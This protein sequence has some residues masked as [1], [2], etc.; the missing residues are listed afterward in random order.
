MST[1]TAPAA[2]VKRAPEEI[3][4]EV[5]L[6]HSVRVFRPTTARF[7]PRSIELPDD[8][9]NP[10]ADELRSAV[11]GMTAA[12]QR[13]HDAPMM[14]KKMRDAENARKMS[15]FKRVLIR[16]LL[17]DRVM[18]QGVFEPASTV[19]MVRRFVVASLRDARNVKFYLFVTPPKQKLTEMDKTLWSLGLVPA[20][21]I[22]M[23]I[24][25][26]EEMSSAQLLKDWLLDSMED[27]PESKGVDR[28][29][30]TSNT[31]SEKDKKETVKKDTVSQ[32]TKT[33]KI[34]KWFK[35]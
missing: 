30:G 34:P 7:D 9:F 20:A 2:P 11:A 14:T 13:L 35:K 18:L 31:P 28:G 27:A 25:S 12:S 29:V 17:P 10:T 5:L 8:F 4:R 32:K 15:R 3:A 16:I 22:H 19:N 23:G 6:K 26:G 33:K 24:E 1:D 21:F